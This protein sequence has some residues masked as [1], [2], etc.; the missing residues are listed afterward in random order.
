MT[1][2]G[3]PQRITPSAVELLA[4]RPVHVRT[5]RIQGCCGGHASIPVAEPGA[6]ARPDD[7]ECYQVAGVVVFVDSDVDRTDAAWIIDTDGFA[8]WRRLVVLGL[9]M[10]PGSDTTSS[11]AGEPHP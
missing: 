4:G 9:E 2:S 8:R 7:A 3:G 5:K 1:V 6:P 10:T 11:P